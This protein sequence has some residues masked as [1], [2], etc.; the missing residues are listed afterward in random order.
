MVWSWF[1]NS[2]IFGPAL[3]EGPFLDQIKPKSHQIM[4][5]FLL[6]HIK[7]PLYFMVW[8]GLVLVCKILHGQ[9]WSGLQKSESK[10]SGLVMVWDF[11]KWSGL[12][13]RKELNAQHYSLH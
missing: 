4:I 5:I 9:K 1:W 11:Y 10:W 12:G 3:K 13:P 6:K 2:K 7:I 8:S